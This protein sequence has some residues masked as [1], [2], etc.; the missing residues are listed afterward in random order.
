ME[1]RVFLRATII[2]V[3]EW[4]TYFAACGFTPLGGKRGNRYAGGD[5]VYPRV[6]LFQHPFFVF[7]QCPN[8]SAPRPSNAA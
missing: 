4:S 8:T 1:W 5:P 3:D 6:A 2:T 7:L